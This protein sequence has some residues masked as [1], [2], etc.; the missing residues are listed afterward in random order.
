[1]F[2]ML[3]LFKNYIII[4]TVLKAE[5]ELDMLSSEIF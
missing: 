1:M 3:K 5:K 4:F 2:H